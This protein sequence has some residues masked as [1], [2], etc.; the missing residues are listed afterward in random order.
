MSQQR[1]NGN[2]MTREPPLLETDRLLL[3]PFELGDFDAYARNAADP[4]AARFLGGPQ[5]RSVAWRG[6][7]TMAGAWQLTGCSMFSVIEKSTGDWVGRVGPWH[8]EGWP[9]TEVGWGIV[10]ARWGRGFATEAAVAAI[11]WA[12]DVLGWSEVIHTI[13][14]GNVASIAVAE[15][16]GSRHRGPGLLPAPYEGLE[17]GIWGQTAAEWR[18]RRRSV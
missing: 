11:D 17:V 7:M 1:E 13:D 2:A 9:G 4:E 8:P 18:A 3:R 16:L 14:S 15:R 5:P 6:F 12:L 10:R